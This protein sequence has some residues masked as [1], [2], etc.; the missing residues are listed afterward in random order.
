MSSFQ[1]GPFSS[2]FKPIT[3]QSK[4]K[5]PALSDS[6]LTEAMATSVESAPFGN[7][8]GWGIPFEIGEMIILA[9]EAVSIEIDPTTARWLIFMHTSD[10]RDIDTNDSGFFS[11]MRGQGQLAEHAAN[12]VIRYADGHEV[13]VPIQRRFQ[14]GSFQRRWGEN[15]F[16]AVAHQKPRPTLPPHEQLSEGWGWRQTRVDVADSMPWIN[17]MWAWENP[18]PEKEITR[19]RFEPTSGVVI[20]SA[21]SAGDCASQPLRWVARR[22]ACLSLPEGIAFE[23]KLDEQGLTQHIQL[24]L[25]QVISV[26]PRTLYP[27]D[28]WAGSYNNQNPEKSENELLIEYTAHPEAPGR[29]TYPDPK[30]GRQNQCFAAGEPS[31]PTRHPASGGAGQ[32]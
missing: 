3:L 7:F 9:D 8:V 27:N 18:H 30:S 11:P 14:I 31:N 5:L 2:L 15:C 20:V 32:L 4:V 12:Y 26:K 29:P 13:S 22:K 24:D 17:W 10:L 1:D 25:G 16:E 19:L 21:V 28:H 23:N 6:D